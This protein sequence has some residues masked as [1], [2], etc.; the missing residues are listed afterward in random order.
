MGNPAPS[1]VTL[2]LCLVVGHGPLSGR[3]AADELRPHDP[4][5]VRDLVQAY[6]KDA[7]GPYQTLRWFCVDG[8]VLLPQQRCPAPGGIQHAV[9]KDAVRALAVKSHIF[10]GQILAGTSNEDFLDQ[11]HQFSRA[12]QYAVERYLRAVDDGWIMRRAYSFRGAVQAEDEEAWSQHFLEW[13]V[14]RD[15]LL[16]SHFYLARELARYLPRTD[17][18]PRASLI[19]GLAASIADEVPGFVPLRL[20]IHG[21]PEP[22]DLEAVRAYRRAHPNAETTDVAHKLD[23]L[24]KEM[25]AAYASTTLDRFSRYVDRYRP[26]RPVGQGI[27]AV[28]SDREPD[29][30]GPAL[31][32]LLLTIRQ[33]I[34]SGR[35]PPATRVSLLSLS[36]EAEAVLL[37]LVG[38]WRTPTLR[39]ALAKG[40]ALARAAAGTGVLEA[41]EW[42]AV[43]PG[44]GSTEGTV[45][46]RDLRW[47]SQRTLGVVQWGTGMVN[48]TYG[49]VA[50]LFESFEPK[51]AS[52]IDDRIR[53]SVLLPLGETAARL[54]QAAAIQSGVM[55][56]ILGSSSPGS[57]R[58]LNP[59]AAVGELVVI[60]GSPE[61][62]D[63]QGDKIYVLNYPPPDLKPVAGILTVSEGNAVSHVQLLARNLGIPNA[64]LG[65]ES[66]RRARSARGHPGLLC[67]IHGRCRRLEAR[68][69]DARPTSTRSWSHGG[70]AEGDERVTVPA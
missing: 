32:S 3:G 23:E 36:N 65:E 31:C 7:L 24:E 59:G 60:P 19:R 25:A 43:A 15:D 38:G 55:N 22:S 16:A 27:R 54:R 68:R 12:K 49:D 8:S 48:A 37:T 46:V 56:Q 39:T 28:V 2:C 11:A 13:L 29:K 42:D 62:L 57:F 4:A 40:E 52:F 47:R 18:T 53:S 61:G 6:Q 20:K 69:P 26:D 41:W 5:A 66:L 9:P 64:V 17:S 58:G 1:A 63:L 67:G 10:L 44:L 34:T 45:T 14:A 50:E 21:Q 70:A 35:H 33:E 51:A 30:S